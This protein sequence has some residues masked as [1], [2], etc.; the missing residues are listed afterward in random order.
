MPP[1]QAQ[2]QEERSAKDASMASRGPPFVERTQ[3]ERPDKTIE[4]WLQD[5]CR[6]GQQG[7]LTRCWAETGSRPTALKQTEYEWIYL[8]GAVNPLTG[9]SS[10]LLAPTVNT[11]YMNHHL[12]FISEQAS[13][14]VHV[15]L[16]LDQAGWHVAKTLKVPENISFL[17]LPAYSPEL[18]SIERLW[19]YFK[20]HYL[21]NR[22]YTDYKDLLR[23]CRDAW[24]KITPE[25]FRTICNTKWIPR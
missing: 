1:T 19:A 14:D 9:A 10:A 8:F 17:H 2:A 11:D 24:N 25:Q 15:I 16:V 6:I 20:S 23:S 13:S 12:R 7:T 21:S 4:I 5:E 3:K 18:N 22:A